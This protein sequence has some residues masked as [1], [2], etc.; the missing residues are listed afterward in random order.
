MSFF[1]EQVIHQIRLD[2]FFGF[3]ISYMNLTY[4]M[5]QCIDKFD[6]MDVI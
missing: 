1:F 6:H 5:Y 3:T 4:R 2:H